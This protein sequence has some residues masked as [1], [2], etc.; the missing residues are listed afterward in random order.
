MSAAFDDNLIFDVATAISTEARAF[1]NAGRSGLDY[2]TPNINQFKDPRWGRGQETPGE[3][4]FRVQQYLKALVAGFEGP[5]EGAGPAKIIATCKHYAAYD[6]ED[7]QGN[8]RYDFDA[9]VSQQDLFEYYL[10][11]FQTCARDV[12][13]GS[14]MCSY[15]AING[16]PTCADPW[17]LQTVL[18]EHWNWKADYQYVVSDC[19]AVENIFTP[20]NYTSTKE[21]AVAAALKAGTDLDCGTYYPSHLPGAYEQNLIN[22]TILDQALTRLISAQIKVGYF[23]AASATPYRSL[24]WANVSTPAHQTL[25]QVAAE[26]SAVLLKNNG[27][28]PIV[29]SEDKPQTWALVGA[30]ANASTDLQGNYPGIAPFLHSPIYAAEQLPG[31]II[32]YSPATAASKDPLTDEFLNKLKHADV[33]LFADGISNANEA[34]TLDRTIISWTPSQLSL[35]S[36]LAHLGKP[37]IILQMGGG[38]LDDTPLLQNTNI[39]AIIWGGYPGQDGGPALMNIIIGAV[40][41]AGRL[42]VTQYPADYADAV[43]MTDMALRP[44]EEM[45]RLGRTYRWFGEAVLPFGFG[46]HYTT[47]DVFVRDEADTHTLKHSYAIKDLVENCDRKQHT[48]LDTCPFANITVSVRNTGLSPATGE[49]NNITSDYVLLAFLTT[50]DAAKDVP[51]KT[52]VG[53]TRLSSI[54]AGESKMATIPLT[55]ASLARRD[56]HGDAVLYSGRY[57]IEFDVDGA[58]SVDF[59]LVGDEAVVIESVPRMD[60]GRLKW[61]APK[62]AEFAAAKGGEQVRLGVEVE[63]L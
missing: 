14:I 19:G 34:E 30:W 48:Y 51:L 59:E 57:R 58:A 22:D 29:V 1:S 40:A 11:P 8:L 23:D 50:T 32:H 35:I 16:I 45:G 42:P 39:S 62:E 15:N 3:D 49:D 60:E 47:F 26:K 31:V 53:Y 27:V 9:K 43:P 6:L 18:R 5:Q 17:L 4:S 41:P 46:L 25:A 12:Q 10:A 33:V 61:T 13:V 2:W 36:S 28:L 37:L 52:L 54:A 55:L 20:H 7:W 56:T 38:Q 44:D 21:Q 63:E 24:S